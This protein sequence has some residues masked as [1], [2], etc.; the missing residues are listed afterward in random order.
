MWKMCSFTD[1]NLHSYIEFQ[2]EMCHKNNKLKYMQNSFV[3]DT[4]DNTHLWLNEKLSLKLISFL[5]SSKN[6]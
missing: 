4:V 2:I 6:E 3:N 5:V 1:S